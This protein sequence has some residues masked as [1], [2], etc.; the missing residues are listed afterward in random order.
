[1][2]KK[3]VCVLSQFCCAT[4]FCWWDETYILF[5]PDRDATADESI[6]T[7]EAELGKQMSFN[8]VT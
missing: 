1:M 3:W 4:E 8:R 6:H 2:K 5:T 7:T